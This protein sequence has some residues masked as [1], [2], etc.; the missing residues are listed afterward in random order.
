MFIYNIYALPNLVCAILSLAVGIFVLAN[1]IN[2]PVNR[3]FFCLALIIS[4]WQLGTS[5]VLFSQNAETAYL[6]SKFVYFGAIFIPSTTYYFIIIFLNRENQKKF[7]LISYL[8]GIIFLIWLLMTNHFLSGVNIYYWGYWF[9][10]GLYHPLYLLY[11]IIVLIATF[12]N[13]LNSLQNE[14]NCIIRLRRQYMLIALAVAYLGAVDFFAN[15]GVIFYPFGYLPI[16]MFILIT[17]IAIVRYR[18]MDIEI[19]IRETAVF[20]GIFGFSIGVFILAIAAGEQVLQPY[21]GQSKW[22]IPAVSLLLV[23]FAIRPIEKMVYNIVG[24]YLFRKKF[25]YQKTLHDAAEGMSKVRDPKKLL[26]LIVHIVSA[27]LK[28]EGVAVLLYDTGQ[29]RYE[30]KAS[31]GGI[32]DKFMSLSPGNSLI[33]WLSEKKNPLTLEEIQRWSSGNL[34]KGRP[35]MLVSDLEQIK[36]TM[37]YLGAAVCVPCF[38]RDEIL[39]ILVLG[40]KKSG[41]FFSQDDLSLFNALSNEAAIALKNSQLYFEIDKKAGETETL[42]KREHKLFIHASIAFA[43][44]IDARDSYT[45]GHSERVTSISLAILDFIGTI[46]EID[47]NPVFRQR[48]QVAAVL[49]DIGKIGVPD[50]ILHKP[51]RLNSKEEKLI[52]RHPSIGADIISHIRGLRDLIG[53]IKHHHERY[54]GKGYPEGLKAEQIPI[55]ARI[56][57]VADTFDAMTSDRPYRKGLDIMIAR[58]EIQGNSAAQ[59]DPY[60]V[61]AFLKAFEQGRVK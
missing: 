45:H 60:I 18:L 23:T 1:N 39:G 3:S 47:E 16:F 48:L 30:I 28:L 20:A 55:M 61:A 51:S 7:V 11:F 36:D 15:Y 49:H 21:I 54:D 12:F 43:A 29:E 52:Q 5:L 40:G 24:K 19:I 50:D 6:W 8:V 4:L 2:F 25:E 14:T 59:F 32:K 53:G 38:F 35:G 37:Q 57:S 41:D 27:K 9:K 58:E 34:G 31:R 10:A 26:S 22:I 44:A 42:Y 46:K 33:Q 17:G 56:I 13:L